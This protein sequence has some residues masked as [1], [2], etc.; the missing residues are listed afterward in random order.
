[1]FALVMKQSAPSVACCGQPPLV[2][3]NP[4]RASPFISSV[5]FG[6]FRTQFGSMKFSRIALQFAKDSVTEKRSTKTAGF[7]YVFI[8]RTSVHFSSASRRLKTAAA[9]LRVHVPVG[10][11]LP[12]SPE[13]MPEATSVLTLL[14]AQPE[15][16]LA[17]A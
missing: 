12:L 17:S 5:A 10:L 15:T 3:K 6:D 13:M 1:M 7:V 2:M 16:S 9:S 11:S 8:F 14:S 4:I